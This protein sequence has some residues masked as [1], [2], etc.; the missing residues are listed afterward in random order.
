MLQK[1]N[2]SISFIVLGRLSIIPKCPKTV[3]ECEI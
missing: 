2:E 3:C 1:G